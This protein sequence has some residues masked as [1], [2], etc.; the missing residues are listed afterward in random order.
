MLSRMHRPRLILLSILLTLGLA[1][2]ACA[3]PPDQGH[4]VDGVVMVAPPPPQVDVMSAP[5]QD[6][7]LWIGGYW[8]WVGG[9]YDWVPGRWIAP[10]P[11][12]RW[13]A[14]QWVRQRDG[15]RLRPGH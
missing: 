12:Y 14:H 2:G 15:W 4:T 3:V 6:R 9:W 7:Y 8:N 10:R 1:L 13:V 5:P 11:G